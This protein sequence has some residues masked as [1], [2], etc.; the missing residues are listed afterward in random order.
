[1]HGRA[2]RQCERPPPGQPDGGGGLEVHAAVGDRVELGLGGSRTVS[3]SSV[4]PITSV[5]TKGGAHLGHAPDRGH[6]QPEVV[7][8]VARLHGARAALSR[9]VQCNSASQA[10]K[11]GNPC[12]ALR[13]NTPLCSSSALPLPRPRPPQIR[14]VMRTSVL[15]RLASGS[16]LS[17]DR[18]CSSWPRCSHDVRRAWGLSR[19]RGTNEVPV[20]IVFITML[21]Y[22]RW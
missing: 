3:A 17:L 19:C 18:M 16:K 8:R 4:Y 7:P 9:G 11:S 6:R 2:K 13:A 14:S 1:M 10:A 5:V 21:G 20:R 12:L 15:A 22:S